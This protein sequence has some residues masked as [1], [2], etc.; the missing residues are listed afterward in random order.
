MNVWRIHNKNDFSESKG[1]TKDDL[2]QF[3]KTEGIIGVGWSKIT[4]CIDSEDAIRKEAE[5]YND[6]AT[7]GLKAVNAM[8]SMQLNDLIWARVNGIYYLCKVTGLWINR[9]AEGK[10]YDLDVSN[11][12]NVEWL[13]VGMEDLIPGHV[14]S[15]FRPAAAAQKI[16]NVEAISKYIWNKIKEL[17]EYEI[18]NERLNIWE[19]LSDKDIEE[20]VLL[21]I[22]IEKGYYIL[23]QSLKSTTK[24]YECTMINKNGQ[25]AFPQVK[26]GNVCVKADDYMDALKRREDAQIFLFTVC[27][28]YVRNDSP[29]VHYLTRKEIENFMQNTKMLPELTR[30]WLELAGFIKPIVVN[31]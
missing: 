2:I 30:N 19:L 11:Y 10:H 9:K 21:Y 15:S 7:A 3:C 20:V 22:Q 4:T 16:K 28:K 5:Q 12:V 31:S 1:Y 18:K 23:T 24:E 29:N 8:R 6:R 14:I 17:N 25:L 26:S 27:E 13:T